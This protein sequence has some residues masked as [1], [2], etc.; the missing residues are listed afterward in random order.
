MDNQNNNNE[1]SSTN[2]N[3]PSSIFGQFFDAPKPA[4]PEETSEQP[5][6]QAPTTLNPGS[7]LTE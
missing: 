2:E 3:V 6:A 1:S 4:A 7:Q 5:V